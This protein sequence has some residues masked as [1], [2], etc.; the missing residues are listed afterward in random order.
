VGT[1]RTGPT[2]ETRVELH[3]ILSK[4][5]VQH[6][7]C[8][9]AGIAAGH[10]C[11]AVNTT[12]HRH[13]P[14]SEQ[15]QGTWHSSEACSGRHSECSGPRA[16][17]SIHTTRIVLD[18]PGACGEQALLAQRSAKQGIMALERLGT[19]VRRN[20]QPPLRTS[21]TQQKTLAIVGCSRCIVCNITHLE[22]RR[23]PCARGSPI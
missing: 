11:S 12:R 3:P 10:A 17:L 19:K 9:R 16:A 20:A 2:V 22:S 4:Y 8:F 5:C 21:P 14:V 7:Y 1:G 15:L 18:P 23:G 13:P 6:N